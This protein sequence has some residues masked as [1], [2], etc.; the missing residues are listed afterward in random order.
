MLFVYDPRNENYN[1][2]TKDKAS[3]ISSG[4]DIACYFVGEDRTCAICADDYAEG[5]VLLKLGNCGHVFHG[6]CFEGWVYRKSSCPL[7]RKS[8][9]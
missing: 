4:P 2:H 9:Y 3:N 5:E 8:I 1:I 7:C 6:E